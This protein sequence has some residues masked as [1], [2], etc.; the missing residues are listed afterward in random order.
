VTILERGLRFLGWAAK[1]NLSGAQTRLCWWGENAREPGGSG[2]EATRLLGGFLADRPLHFS[3]RQENGANIC[4]ITDGADGKLSRGLV[5]IVPERFG[6]L[7]CGKLTV[8]LP[9]GAAAKNWAA[10][11]V[12]YSTEKPPQVSAIALS[13]SGDSLTVPVNQTVSGAW[14][15]M[16]AEDPATLPK[17]VQPSPP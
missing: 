8:A 6:T 1:N 12:S 14:M 5:T 17:P 4:L 15:L 3:Q 13:R 7:D 16:F 9:A 10:R 11:A 2:T